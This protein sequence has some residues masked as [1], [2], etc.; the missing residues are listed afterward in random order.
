MPTSDL[1][2]EIRNI[3]K[4]RNTKLVTPP[5]PAKAEGLARHLVWLVV[6]VLL[7][8]ITTTLFATWYLPSY[9]YQPV[10]NINQITTIGKVDLAGVLEKTAPATVAIFNERTSAA[11]APP[12]QQAYI[13]QDALGQGVVLSSDGWIVTTNQ[14]VSSTKGSYMVA[15]MDGALRPV[16]LMVEDSHTDL[17]YLK[18]DVAN[19][20]AAAFARP[21]DINVGEQVVAIALGSQSSKRVAVPRFLISLNPAGVISRNDDL[22]KSSEF[23]YDTMTIDWGLPSNWQGAVVTQVSGR[24]VGLAFGDEEIIYIYPLSTMD[25]IVAGLF[26]NSQVSR[27]VLGVNYVS[28]SS[29]LPFIEAKGDWL[30]NGTLLTRYNASR[31]AVKAGSPAA[32][33]GLKEN[34]VITSVAGER[35]NGLLS[36]SYLISQYSPGTK[37]NLM[38][39][40]QGK[41]S[42]VEVT[43]GEEITK[44]V[45]KE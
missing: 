42:Q 33:A 14:V 5:P 4:E 39:W 19:L 23:V 37:L 21:S 43:L 26:T 22:V 1:D 30:T 27:P 2:K 20:T 34:D 6:V 29:A 35:V 16:K 24:V 32:K 11:N 3:Y 15:T 45:I 7:S 40:R 8:V 38:V 13:T 44:A 10:E 36:L 9:L 31:P 41:E 12:W 17:V 25:K 28:M 18:I